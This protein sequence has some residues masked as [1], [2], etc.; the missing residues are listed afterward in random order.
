MRLISINITIG[1]NVTSIGNQVF[2]D[3]PESE[4]VNIYM[5]IVIDL[6]KNNKNCK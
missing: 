3:N 5:E 4:V 2:I 6:I 1:S